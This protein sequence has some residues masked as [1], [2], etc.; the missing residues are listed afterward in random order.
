[1]TLPPDFNPYER[2]P[3]LQPAVV[4]ASD[5]VRIAFG[6]AGIRV[7]RVVLAVEIEDARLEEELPG[8]LFRTA[9]SWPMNEMDKGA[10]VA[11]EAV[12]IFQMGHASQQTRGEG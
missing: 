8:G 1:M 11:K 9:T 2:I 12:R 3:E 4:E 5:F 7:T 10:E 6:R